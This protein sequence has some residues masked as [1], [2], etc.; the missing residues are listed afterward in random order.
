LKGI[1]L[2]H[3]FLQ[4]IKNRIKNEEFY[5]SRVL[6]KLINPFYFSRSALLENIGLF[7][8]IVAG[9]VLDVGCGRKPYRKIFS[10]KEY[11]GLEIDTPETRRRGSADIFY[12]GKTIPVDSCSFDCIFMSQ[13]FE[14]MF[15]PES[16][17][18]E[19]WRV[20]R[21]E[22]YLLLTVPFIWDEHEQPFD[23][24]RYT[25]FG[26]IHILKKNGFRVIEN[27]K[28][29]ADT[30]VIFQLINAYLYKV[31]LTKNR[32]ANLFISILFMSPVNIIGAIFWRLLPRNK[33]LY[34]DNIICARKV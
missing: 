16:V 22:G 13:V 17:L 20:L 33:D 4:K 1:F 6:G 15:N 34:L 26:I 27:K 14:H 25:S 23:Y 8:Q 29:L 11:I 12:D 5:P 7:S 21:S 3:N 9:K 32:Y 18:Q 24:A 31:L 30:R 10:C 19:L 2:V 28:T